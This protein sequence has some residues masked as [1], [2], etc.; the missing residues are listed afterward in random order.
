MILVG[1]GFSLMG[2]VKP[3]LVV[4][5]FGLGIEWSAVRW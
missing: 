2:V 5:I 1:V 4:K 3:L